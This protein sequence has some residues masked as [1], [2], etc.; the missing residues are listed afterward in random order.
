MF[1]PT[2][3][4]AGWRPFLIGV[5]LALVLVF[6]IG[7]AIAQTPATAAFDSLLRSHVKEGAVDYGAFAASAEFRRYVDDLAKPANLARRDEAL[8]Y[9]INAYN[10]LAIAGILDGLSP[11]TLLGRVRYFKLK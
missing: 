5:G 2:P 3:P 11:A 10:A 8:A 7:V 4:A 9:Y 1:R 6:A